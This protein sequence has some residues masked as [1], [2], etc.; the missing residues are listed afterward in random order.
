[1]NTTTL[2][3]SIELPKVF[4]MFA[5]SN[6][7]EEWSRKIIEIPSKVIINCKH[8]A[9]IDSPAI[10]LLFKFRNQLIRNGCIL[11]LHN[12]DGNLLHF[13]NVTSLDK[14]FTIYK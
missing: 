13:F 3:L 1:M 2:E 7:N 10:S 12:V 14:Y 4:D 5:I 9:F 11:E 8:V 6:V